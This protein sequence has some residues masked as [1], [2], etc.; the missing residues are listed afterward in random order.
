MVSNLATNV[1]SITARFKLSKQR[2]GDHNLSFTLDVDFALP[3]QGITAIFGHSGSGKTTLLRCVAGLEKAPE[4]SLSV[5]QQIW[6]DETQFLPT[7][8]RSIGYVFQEASLFEH[9]TARQNIEFATKRASTKASPEFYQN[10]IE[11]LGIAQVLDRYPEQ[12]SGGEQQRV[13]IA[14]ALLIQPQLLLMDEPLASLDYARKQE[15]LA[16][17][18]RVQ[19]QFN[20][21]ILYVSHSMDEVARLAD[22]TLVMEK[23]RIIAQ[24]TP[25]E[26]F[27]RIDL[28]FPQ[29]EDI[30]VVLNG[31]IIERDSEWHLSKVALSDAHLWVRD[32]GD[33][34][35][36]PI[37]LRILAKDV[38]LA[39]QAHQDTSIANRLH[40]KVSDIVDD[41]DPAMVL[42]KVEVTKDMLI[43]RV[44]KR[45]I[46]HLN[47]S[48]G[49][50]VWAQVKSVAIVR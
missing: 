48:V 32:G 4:G 34:V 45:S 30:G 7:H 17:L 22:H 27:S 1:S 35:A 31:S 19:Q 42:V 40:G 11:T 47:L 36:Q 50:E 29:Q 33:A 21:P 12:L 41:K 39:L 10:V 49:S 16:C 6:Q 13:A 28:P 18:E 43:A 5:G 20:T 8:R 25:S 15:I 9:L 26:V 23:G 14:R 24:G 2:R 38:S 3:V 37:R 44:T 46:V